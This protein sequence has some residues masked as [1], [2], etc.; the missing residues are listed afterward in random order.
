MTKDSDGTGILHDG[1]PERFRVELGGR[2]LLGTYG[3]ESR[4][5]APEQNVS[6]PNAPAKLAM[7]LT[8]FHGRGLGE[9]RLDLTQRVPRG[10]PPRVEGRFEAESSAAGRTDPMSGVFLYDVEL[11]RK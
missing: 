4:L 2:T 8:S 7:T 11:A 10:L 5:A 1:V 9:V 6:F 3:V